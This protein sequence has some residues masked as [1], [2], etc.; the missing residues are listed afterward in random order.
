MIDHQQNFFLHRL[1]LKPVYVS[2]VPVQ[3][4]LDFY[5]FHKH[6]TCSKLVECNRSMLKRLK[7]KYPSY[8]NTTP[9]L[10]EENFEWL[11]NLRD[12]LHGYR[13]TP[14]LTGG[15]LL[16]TYK[17]CECTVCPRDGKSSFCILRLVQRLRSYSLHNVN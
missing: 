15:T 17:I 1:H 11:L 12:S 13:M 5:L 9:V 14:M 4:P 6:L 16:G 10:T 7:R 3:Y 2:T 8:F